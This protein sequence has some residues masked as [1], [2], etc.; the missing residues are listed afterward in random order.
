MAAGYADPSYIIVID[1]EV[2]GSHVVMFSGL[3]AL[4]PKGGI[5]RTDPTDGCRSGAIGFAI[6]TP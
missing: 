6:E 5:A 4:D 1:E 3:T 2:V